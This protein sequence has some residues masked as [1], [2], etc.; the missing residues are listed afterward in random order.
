MRYLLLLTTAHFF[1]V[2][3]HLLEKFLEVIRLKLVSVGLLIQFSFSGV[4][5]LRLDNIY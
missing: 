4:L 2:D 3:D 1:G 5:I